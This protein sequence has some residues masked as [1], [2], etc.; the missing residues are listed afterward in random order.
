LSRGAELDHGRRH[1]SCGAELDHDHRRLT[2]GA[3]L[4]HDRRRCLGAKRTSDTSCRPRLWSHVV[5]FCRRCC[6]HR[7]ALSLC[8]ACQIAGAACIARDSHF[9]L[10]ATRGAKLITIAAAHFHACLATIFDAGSEIP[11][12]APFICACVTRTPVRQAAASLHAMLPH[13]HTLALTHALSHSPCPCDGGL[14]DAASASVSCVKPP[15]HVYTTNI[16]H[17][18]SYHACSQMYMLIV[19]HCATRLHNSTNIHTAVS[20]TRRL[21]VR[22]QYSVSI[23][24]PHTRLWRITPAVSAKPLPLQSPL[25]S[26]ISR[27]CS[28]RCPVV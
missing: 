3:E 2:R 17:L 6:M 24:L 7:A 18:G 19:Q 15:S 8:A 28:S 4:D 27:S 5:P 26:E 11:R 22:V 23:S 10:H 21:R 1:L 25:R 9:V 12:S 20:G 14:S 16:V 13:T